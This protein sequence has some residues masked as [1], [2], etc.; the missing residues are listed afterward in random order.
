[1][2]GYYSLTKYILRQSNDF[3]KLIDK[4]IFILSICLNFIAQHFLAILIVVISIILLVFLYKFI[5]YKSS[6]DKE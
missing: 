5:V 4:F 6:G 1:M 3:T 2:I